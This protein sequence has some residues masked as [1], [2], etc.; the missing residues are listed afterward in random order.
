MTVTLNV[1]D[2]IERLKRFDPQ[3]KVYL[4]ADEDDA[5]FEIEIP[6]D[7]A[8]FPEMGVGR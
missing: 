8:I 2:L 1:K 7:F 6:P 4:Q 5:F 3:T